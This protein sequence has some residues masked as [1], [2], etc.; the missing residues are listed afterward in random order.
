MW[1]WH[2]ATSV[3]GCT[4]P[5]PVLP[6]CPAPEPPTLVSPP[7]APVFVSVLAVPPLPVSV[8]EEPL[9]LVVPLPPEPASIASSEQAATTTK[10]PAAASA[11]HPMR[12]SMDGFTAPLPSTPT[13]RH[14]PRRCR[15]PRC[16]RHHHRR[17]WESARSR[18]RRGSGT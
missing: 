12:C 13:R 14:H 5:T 10:A 17:R 4:P 9:P 16:R 7:A 15:C 2:C 18:T 11:S 6:P 1:S 3:G 8:P